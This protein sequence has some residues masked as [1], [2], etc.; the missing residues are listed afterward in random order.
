MTSTSRKTGDIPI[1]SLGKFVRILQ[2]VHWKKYFHYAETTEPMDYQKYLGYAGLEI[3][4]TPEK[5]YS[6]GLNVRGNNDNL[7][8]SNID[9]ASP[10][11][12]LGLS[13]KDKIVSIN[14]ELPNDIQIGNLRTSNERKQP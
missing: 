3:N 9:R 1:R 6:F 2:V 4:L 8:V 12:N 13:I 10:A 14:D 5:M 7:V 11:W